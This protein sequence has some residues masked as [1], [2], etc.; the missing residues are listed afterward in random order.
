[1]LLW[2]VFFFCLFFDTVFCA[3]RENRLFPTFSISVYSIF[4]FFL[5]QFSLNQCVT[6]YIAVCTPLRR[7]VDLIFTL[8]SGRPFFSPLSVGNK[9]FSHF[10]RCAH[11]SRFHKLWID[12]L[13][14][15]HLMRRSTC[16][17]YFVVFDDFSQIFSCKTN[18]SSC[19]SGFCLILFTEFGTKL[20]MHRTNWINGFCR[21]SYQNG[22]YVAVP[23]FRFLVRSNGHP[24][25]LQHRRSS[26]VTVRHRSSE[27]IE[28]NANCD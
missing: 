18:F 3:E 10:C 12:S 28:R 15:T 19:L 26:L 16:K 25:H 17:L 2:L 4:V 7:G 9:I 1:M 6:F 20:Q 14:Q 22:W 11:V 13:L 23:V 24:Y 27:R 21:M 5:S 8:S